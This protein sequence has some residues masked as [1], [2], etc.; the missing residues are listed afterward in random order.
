MNPILDNQGVLRVGGRLEQPTF[1][2]FDMKHPVILPKGHAVTDK[3]ILY[4]HEK[5]GHANRETVCNELRQRFHIPKLRWAIQQAVK[6][7]VWC[8]VNRC[9]PQTPMMAPLPVQRI[10]PQLRPFSSVGVDYLGP[11]EVVVN[12]QWEK[13]GIAL[14]T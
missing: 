9:L 13:R 3:L 8:R 6:S 14:F 1:A 11:V 5:F 4:Y 12:R 10:T 2:T 7:C